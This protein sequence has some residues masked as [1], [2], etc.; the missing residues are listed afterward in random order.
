MPSLTRILTAALLALALSAP[1][2]LSAADGADRLILKDGR[3][4]KGVIVAEDE[5]AVTLQ[6]GGVEREYRRDFIRSIDYA[7]SSAPGTVPALAPTPAA[8]ASSLDLDLCQRYNVPLSEVQ[9]VRRQGM[10]DA[11]LPLVFFIAASAQVLPG[12]VVA[13]RKQGLSWEEIERHYGLEPRRVHFVP[14]PWVPY[15]VIEAS[16]LW[17]FWLLNILTHAHR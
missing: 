12:P 15:P 9:W 17:P 8:Q 7:P 14:G 1:L 6:T 16:I 2:A 13:L 5:K 10:A 3:V 4:L 11:D